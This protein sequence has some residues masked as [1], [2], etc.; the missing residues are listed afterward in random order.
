MSLS[1]QTYILDN[2]GQLQWLEAGSG[3]LVNIA[4]GNT[5]SAGHGHQQTLHFITE[6][7]RCR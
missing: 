4:G 7:A 5:V 3:K 1:P 6:R 2:N